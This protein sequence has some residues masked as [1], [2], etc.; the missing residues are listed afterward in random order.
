[1][2]LEQAVH[3]G[4]G[5]VVLESPLVR[6]GRVASHVDLLLHVVLVLGCGTHLEGEMHFVGSWRESIN[7]TLSV[8]SLVA[9]AVLSLTVQVLERGLLARGSA[10]GDAR[11]QVEQVGVLLVLLDL[12]LH[13]PEVGGRDS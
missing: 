4:S 13:V 6:S 10:L 8:V 1:M 2:L 7:L 9:A 5:R 12:V 11:T 3:H